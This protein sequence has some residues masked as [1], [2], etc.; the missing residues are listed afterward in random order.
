MSKRL[1]SANDLITGT[2]GDGNRELKPSA[3]LQNPFRFGN[4]GKNPR[5]QTCAI[6]N[7]SKSHIVLQQVRSLRL[8]EALKKTP[9]NV[10][11]VF[12]S[13]PILGRKCVERQSREP[14][15]SRLFNHLSHALDTTDMAKKPRVATTSRP[16][17]VSVHDDRDV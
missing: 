7:Y 8:Q 5:R 11:L 17:S 14:E 1:C 15:S 9:K 4:N 10:A 12:R 16:P 13:L 3:L 2:V 6:S